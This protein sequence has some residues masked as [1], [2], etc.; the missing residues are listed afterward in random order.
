MN[1]KFAVTIGSMAS[2]AALAVIYFFP[3]SQH[4][5][6]PRCPI[7]AATHVLCPGCGG[8]R[9]LHEL[10][11]LNI[12]AALHYNA[13]A[14]ILFPIAALWFLVWLYRTARGRDTAE[15]RVPVPLAIGV[16]LL[17]LLFTIARNTGI[18]FTI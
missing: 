16:S 4:D 12:G 8:T 7:Y 15:L 17:A 1:R 18:A 11:H 3:P 14:T 10:L 9:A 5:F 13:L 2:M 6:Y